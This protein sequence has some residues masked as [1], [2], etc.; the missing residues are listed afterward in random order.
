MNSS[1]PT[2]GTTTTGLTAAGAAIIGAATTLPPS[3]AVAASSMLSPLLNEGIIDANMQ[4][5]PVAALAA[6]IALLVTVLDGGSA[7]S[8]DPGR[9]KLSINR[10]ITHAPA[11]PTL[12][13]PSL[14]VELATLLAPPLKSL[15]LLR[16]GT[17]ANR[18]GLYGLGTALETDSKGPVLAAARLEHILLLSGRPFTTVGL[19]VICSH[20]SVTSRL[21][22]AQLLPPSA[23]LLL[24]SSSP[25]GMAGIIGTQPPDE[26]EDCD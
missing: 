1:P 18:V 8:V 11:A 26:D 19:H 3:A 5:T 2:F 15:S 4:I 24:D 23:L 6:V 22:D 21:V 13:G 9:M 14:L 25:I 16:E 10:S 7:A 20:T 17:W 12:P